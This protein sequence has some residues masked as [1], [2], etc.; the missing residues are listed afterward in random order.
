MKLRSILSYLAVRVL[1]GLHLLW[2]LKI[3]PF[4]RVLKCPQ[5]TEQLIPF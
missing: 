3:F 4:T 5:S 1:A 2:D